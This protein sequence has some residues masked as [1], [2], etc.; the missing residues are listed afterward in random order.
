MNHTGEVNV[1]VK[2]VITIFIENKSPQMYDLDSF[3]TDCVRMGRG[4]FHGE[5]KDG[6]N[7]IALPADFATVSRA[8]CTFYRMEGA[9][10][11]SDDKSVNGLSMNG[12]KI[13]SKQLHDG[14][15]IYIGQDNTAKCVIAFS[16]R[17]MENI[18]TSK[19]VENSAMDMGMMMVPLTGGQRYVL[20]RGSDCDIVLKHPTVSRHHCIITL[21]NGEY[22]ISD[23]NSVNG[24]I[25]NGSP[26]KKKQKLEQMDKI[27]IADTSMLF[28]DRSIYFNK[29]VGGVSVVANDISKEVRSGKGTKCIMNHV[30]LS[31]E[32]GEFVAIIGGSGAGKTTLL[33]CLSG[34]AEFTLGDILIN[35]E[36]IRTNS[37]S[38]RSI[39]G[40]VPQSDIVY[41][42]LTLER[43]L[44]Y[45]AQLRMPKDTSK[46]EIQQ[47]ID[48]TLK[49]VELEAHR[50]TLISRLSGGQ[51]KR[52]SIAVELLASP[53]L[54]FLDEPSSGL[55]PGTEKNLM[56]MLKRLTL[57]GKT[58]IM[59]THTVQNINMCDRVICMGFGGLLCYSG[60][61]QKALGFFGK[62]GMP[63]IY[64]DLNEHSIDV[65]NRFNKATGSIGIPETPVQTGKEKKKTDLAEDFRQFIVMTKRY[66]EILINSR[67]RLLLL[68]VMPVVLTILV[69]IAFQSD[70]NLY[71]YLN[72][73]ID[74][75]SQPFNVCGDT[76]KLMFAFSCAAFWVGIFNSIQEISKERNIYEREHFTGVRSFPYVMSKFVNIGLLCIIQSFVIMLLLAYFAGTTVTVAGNAAAS[77]SFKISMGKDGIVFTNGGLWF[78]MYLT[79]F[80]MTLN[81]MCLGLAISSAVSNDMALVLC[82]VCL[83]PQILFSGVV[84]ELSGVTETI[85]NIVTCRWANIAYFTSVGT[86]DMYAK[87]YFDQ[88]TWNEIENGVG[89]GYDEAYS[90]AKTYV[91]GLD[92]VKSAWVVLL[93]LSVIC[94]VISIAAL[95]FKRTKK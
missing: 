38:V 69:C 87:Y 3:G 12:A 84:S 65:S 1:T 83:L 78:E 64:E 28:C 29:S 19:G 60:P 75:T 30:S 36:S 59:V 2:S 80:L 37:R 23:N 76:M 32:P 45:S 68:M 7:D 92:P 89:W 21:E 85:S 8:H 67:T 44:L 66:A 57:T 26:L 93:G 73:A 47:K 40:Y 55:D 17:R 51:R 25:L 52:A 16:C 22:Y 33:N 13:T 15:K 9:W 5:Q 10:Y 58:V 74:R 31:I 71:T 46:A 14:D 56:R 62:K 18:Q 4:P 81:A 63:D 72:I 82:P 27:A 20:G 49:M 95:H 70:G 50:G 11:I 79:T 34:M 43:M 94:M 54:F 77:T 39:I 48:E 86:N 41:D 35:G 61:P 88:G 53:K 42:N 24:I 91:F 6:K 90:A